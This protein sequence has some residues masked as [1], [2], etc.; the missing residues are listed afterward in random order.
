MTIITRPK[1]SVIIGFLFL[2]PTF[3]FI[4]VSVLKYTFG[5]PYLYDTIAPT[6]EKLGIKQPIRWNI[7]LLI[8]FG[9]CFPC[10]L[11][12]PLYF[13]LTLKPANIRS[14][15]GSPCLKNAGTWQSFSSI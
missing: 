2:A 15:A 11:T 8:L 1:A 5:Q 10:Y 13:G 3:Y 14:T 12:W 4:L 9:L 7:N 6:F